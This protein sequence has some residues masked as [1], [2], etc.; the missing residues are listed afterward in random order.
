MF[1]K[2]LHR[3]LRFLFYITSIIGFNLSPY[4]NVHTLILMSPLYLVWLGLFYIE[5]EYMEK[6][7]YT[8]I[9]ESYT[10]VWSKYI[11]PIMGLW[12]FFRLL[13][14]DASVDMVI[15]SIGI[16]VFTVSA[17]FS[18]N[19]DIYLSNGRIENSKHGVDSTG[20]WKTFLDDKQRP[21]SQIHHICI[22][23]K[24]SSIREG[25]YTVYDNSFS[26]GVYL[27]DVVGGILVLKDITSEAKELEKKKG[28]FQYSIKFIDIYGNL[29]SDLV[30]DI[31][32]NND[33]KHLIAVKTPNKSDY[34]KEANRKDKPISPTLKE[35]KD[36]SKDS[37][38]IIM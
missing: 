9:R 21:N 31:F 14:L 11:F 5:G 34:I 20:V 18:L 23:Q 17:F 28:L 3:N 35:D 38:K 25:F 4:F 30:A 27:T 19:L 26:D 1:R 12:M 32:N 29:K 15:M 10:V 7:D 22:Q 33:N 13:T 37:S 2:L 6:K 8:G 16:F 36:E 24:E